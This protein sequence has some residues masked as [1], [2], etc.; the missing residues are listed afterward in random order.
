L[1]LYAKTCAA[2]HDKDRLRVDEW[3]YAGTHDHRSHDHSHCTDETN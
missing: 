2:E 1:I 3:G